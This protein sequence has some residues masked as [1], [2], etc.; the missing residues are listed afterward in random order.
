MSL[1]DEN[2]W[3]MSAVTSPSDLLPQ[4][5]WFL[6]CEFTKGPLLRRVDSNPMVEGTVI[7]VYAIDFA[8]TLPQ[9]ASQMPTNL[10]VLTNL[11]LL[12]Q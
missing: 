5:V 2:S 10:H 4:S 11:W 12:T 1:C 6:K 3:P 7:A 9:H 8:A